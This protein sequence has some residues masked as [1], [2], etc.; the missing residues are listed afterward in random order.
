MSTIDIF[1]VDD[2]P[3]LRQGISQALELEEDL[4]VVGE[5]ATGEKAVEQ[6]E[7]GLDCDVILMDISM[8]GMNGVEATEIAK[9]ID[10]GWRI[11]ILTIQDA[12]D[13]LLEAVRAGA[14]GY[15]LKDVEPD[16][17]VSAIRIVAQGGRYFDP[18]LT[19]RILDQV[20]ARQSQTTA[21]GAQE[22][23]EEEGDLLTKRER[24]VLQLMAQGNTNKEIGEKLYI[25]E[26][27][28][29]NHATSLFRKLE[30][31][32]RTEAVVEGIRRGFIS[33]KGER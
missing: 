30:V 2:H 13:Y 1:V 16:I 19:E 8:P 21:A 22:L 27:T 20:A 15:V 3:L 31:G 9:K 23:E 24:Q 33:V 18:Q 6:L 14:D 7:E 25:S 10:A 28:V 5:A 12:D 17:L 32:D 4:C 26:K 11:L 29:K